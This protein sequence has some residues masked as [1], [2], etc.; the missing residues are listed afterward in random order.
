MEPRPL[1]LMDAACEARDRHRV[2]RESW[3]FSWGP[4]APG[5]F[6]QTERELPAQHPLLLVTAKTWPCR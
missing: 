1:V 4:P 5:K 3:P 2:Q 6:S